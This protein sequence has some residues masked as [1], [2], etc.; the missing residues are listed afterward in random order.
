M[1]SAPTV[2]WVSIFQDQAC[3]LIFLVQHNNLWQLT[4]S[5][6]S[7]VGAKT[8]KGPSEAS[9]STRPA[10]FTAANKVENLRIRTVRAWNCSNVLKILEVDYSPR[11]SGDDIGN[12]LVRDERVDD[13]GDHVDHAVAGLDVELL[14]TL[15]VHSHKPLEEYLGQPGRL[16]V[17]EN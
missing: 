12:R 11:I 3:S 17:S 13:L 8:V 6:A 5:K 14:Q 7:L 4:L 1:S 9:V 2:S 15:S 10:A 16:L